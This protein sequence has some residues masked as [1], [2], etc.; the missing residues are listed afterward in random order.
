[1][2]HIPPYGD[3]AARRDLHLPLA[4]RPLLRRS[5]SGTAAS[6]SPST[7]TRSTICTCSWF[8]R[9]GR[10]GPGS[11]SVQLWVAGAGQRRARWAQPRYFLPRLA[12]LAGLAGLA[13]ALRGGAWARG[14]LR[15]DVRFLAARLA[16]LAAG[17]ALT[18]PWLHGRRRRS[19]SRACPWRARG[20]FG[21]SLRRSAPCDGF[22]LAA[23]W[24]AL[25]AD[26]GVRRVAVPLGGERQSRHVLAVVHQHAPR[27]L[28]RDLDLAV[29]E[30]LR[31]EPLA[32]LGVRHDHV[33]VIELAE[34][35]RL[36]V[37]FAVLVEELFQSH[38]SSSSRAS[39]RRWARGRR[40]P[41]LRGVCGTSGRR[42]TDCTAPGEFRLRTS[43]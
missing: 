25:A 22:S 12:A 31:D 17:A 13:A 26:L 19:L 16:A 33:L 7:R 21:G 41:H 29:R 24:R 37:L 11:R 14:G 23:G 43:K 34:F 3:P 18:A 15:P 42:R 32:E 30:D 1:M 27:V 5:C 39:S 35:V 6:P 2:H 4:G 8:G 38:A 20:S 9:A 28:E 36:C 10:G 40:P